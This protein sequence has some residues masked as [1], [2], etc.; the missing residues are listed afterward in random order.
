MDTHENAMLKV[1]MPVSLVVV[2]V[3]VVS[4]GGIWG[5]GPLQT[6]GDGVLWQWQS[7]H[8]AFDD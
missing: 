4:L 5:Y 7:Q 1:P 3:A 8:K 6:D 2:E